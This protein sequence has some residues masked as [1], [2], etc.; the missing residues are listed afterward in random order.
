MQELLNKSIELNALIQE[1]KN[2][3]KIMDNESPEFNST[4]TLIQQYILEKVRIDEALKIWNK[5]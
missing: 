2:C 1:L 4:T 3:A 5:A